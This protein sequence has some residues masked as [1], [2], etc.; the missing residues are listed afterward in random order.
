M[1]SKRLRRWILALKMV[2]DLVQN[3]VL[4]ASWG[5]KSDL[6]RH[7]SKNILGESTFGGVRA[8]NRW[9][10]GESWGCLGAILEGKMVPERFQ[11][12]SKVGS[13]GDFEANAVSQPFS[14]RFFFEIEAPAKAKILQNAVTVVQ[15]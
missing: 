6:A 4:G 2:S 15:N 1:P 5:V 8:M 13:S 12:R 7:V 3:R 10:L 14:Y 9:I 11:E